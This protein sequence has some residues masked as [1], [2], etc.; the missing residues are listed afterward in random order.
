MRLL[1]NLDLLSQTRTIYVKLVVCVELRSRYGDDIIWEFGRRWLQIFRY[2][3]DGGVDQSKNNIRSGLLI[4]KGFEFNCL[5]THD[6]GSLPTNFGN[7][8]TRKV[9][10]EKC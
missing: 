1:E 2:F 7:W 9:V 10:E 5:D 3:G 8:N 4:R 6:E